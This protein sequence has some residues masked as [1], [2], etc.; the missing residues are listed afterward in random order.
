MPQFSNHTYFDNTGNSKATGFSSGTDIRYF[1]PQPGTVEVSASCPKLQ[2]M[3]F[4]NMEDVLNY[5]GISLE[6]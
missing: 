1:T 4:G 3:D 2:V 6:E 5:A